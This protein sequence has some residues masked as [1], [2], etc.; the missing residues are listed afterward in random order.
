[1]KY[2]FD[3]STIDTDLPGIVLLSHGELALGMLDTVNMIMGETC[4]IAAFSL[5]PED[6]PKSYREAFIEAIE[7]FPKGTVIFID[8]FG[9]TPCNQFLMGANKITTT[10]C[11]FTGMNLPIILET[12]TNRQFKFGEELK[13]SVKKASDL[14]IL[15]LTEL[16]TTL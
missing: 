12:I 9:G 15:D 2:F 1:M 5:M 7:S 6:E 16:L 3:K 8:M 4:N 13:K 11:A 10:Y 14:V